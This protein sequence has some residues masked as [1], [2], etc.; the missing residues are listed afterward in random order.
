MSWSV[1]VILAEEIIT[2]IISALVIV[3]ITLAVV[4]LVVTIITMIVVVPVITTVVAVIITSIHV[5][6]AMIGPTVMVITSIRSTITVVEALVTVLVVVVAALGLLGVERYSKGMLQLLAL[7]HG[8]FGVV[9]EP[10]L[11]VH[12]HV[13]VTF[14]EGGRSWWICHV[15]F[16]RSLS[17]PVSSIVVIFLV[18]VV[19][20][21]ILSVN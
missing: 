1:V 8:M 10:A 21:R 4:T 13:E 5:I 2:S 14:E 17:R 15:S 19:H 6:V 7:P 16:T 12:D 3:A 11:V 9:V 20:H 18:E